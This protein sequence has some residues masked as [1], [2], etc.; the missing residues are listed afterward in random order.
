VVEEEQENSPDMFV[1][2]IEALW[3]E[4]DT[5]ERCMRVNW[6]FW[7]E[8]AGPHLDTYREVVSF[9]PFFSSSFYKESTCGGEP[10]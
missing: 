8:E 10:K 9:F 4:F 3:E 7:P 2:Q 6:F 5:R 1:G